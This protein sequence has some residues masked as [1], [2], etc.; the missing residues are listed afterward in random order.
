MINGRVNI[1]CRIIRD[2]PVQ[3]VWVD[4]L[5]QPHLHDV[6]ITTAETEP[7][8]IVRE[9]ERGNPPSID[10]PNICYLEG[11]AHTISRHTSI[12]GF[13]PASTPGRYAHTEVGVG[14]GGL[15]II[16]LHISNG[17]APPLLR[18]GNATSR[19]FELVGDTY[20]RID[21][22]ITTDPAGREVVPT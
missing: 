13:D 18:L 15:F 7:F 9:V 8:A 20:R 22:S 2:I 10:H 21:P 16:T 5:G 6:T 17:T 19:L 14:I 4:D 1:H 11:G 12:G 3:Q